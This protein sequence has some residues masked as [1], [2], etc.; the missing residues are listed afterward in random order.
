MVTEPPSVSESGPS[1]SGR[2]TLVQ[3]VMNVLLSR[4]ELSKSE[5]ME[6]WD[7]DHERYEELKPRILQGRLVVPGPK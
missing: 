5:I 4:G 3:D 6:L 7:L 2:L 1:D